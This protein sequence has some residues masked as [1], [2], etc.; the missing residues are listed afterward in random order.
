MTLSEKGQNRE[1]F[2]KMPGDYGSTVDEYD[3]IEGLKKETRQTPFLAIDYESGDVV[4]HEAG[5]E[6]SR[7]EAMNS[8]SVRNL[9]FSEETSEKS[10]DRLY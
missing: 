6:K 1:Y 4:G 8:D 10:G 9:R 3:Y 5:S 7:I 2:D